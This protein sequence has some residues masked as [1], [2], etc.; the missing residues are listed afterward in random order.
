[1]QTTLSLYIHP[2]PMTVVKTPSLQESYGH[3]PQG[4]ALRSWT[5]VGGRTP[6]Q[7]SLCE[8]LERRVLAMAR[9]RRTGVLA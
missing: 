1:M 9:L 2:I 8:H 7:H 5:G 6:Q 3:C 4:A